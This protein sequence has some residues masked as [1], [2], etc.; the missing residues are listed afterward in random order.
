MSLFEMEDKKE[1][2][3]LPVLHVDNYSA[4][5]VERQFQ[6][7]HTKSHVCMQGWLAR[8]LYPS[9]QSQTRFRALVAGIQ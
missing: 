2:I 5:C 8:V 1:H 6:P 3:C 9:K 4:P 7:T